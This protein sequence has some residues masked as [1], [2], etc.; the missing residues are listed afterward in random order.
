M[1]ESLDLKLPMDATLNI[2]CNKSAEKIKLNNPTYPE[3]NVY[4]TEKCVLFSTIP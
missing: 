2:W 4:P 3:T 1:N